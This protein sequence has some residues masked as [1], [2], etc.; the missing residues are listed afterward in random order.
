MKTTILCAGLALA[1]TGG[2][3]QAQDAATSPQ[4]IKAT[5]SNGVLQVI[6][7]P[8]DDR[9]EVM[10]DSAGIR[11][12]GGGVAIAGGVPT[13]SN[14]VLIDIDA[15]AGNDRVSLEGVAMAQIESRVFGHEGNDLL[16][17]GDG[18]DVL[19]GGAGNDVLIGGRGNDVAMGQD[20]SDLLIW[21]DGDGSDFL[22]GG[23]GFDFVQVNGSND[24]DDLD[25][26]AQA[27]GR[28]EVRFQ[29]NNLGLFTLDIGTVEN[30][31]LDG[32]GGNDRLRASGSIP[33]LALTLVGGD[34]DDEVRGGDG[35]DVLRGGAGNDTLIGG[36][37]NDVVLGQDGSDQLVWNDGD[38]SDMLEGGAGFDF[39]QVN[40][41]N[42]AGDDFNIDPDDHQRVRFRRTNLDLFT[43]DIGT[44]ENLDVN[45]QGG[46]DVIIGSTGLVGLISLDLD[47]GEGNDLLIGGGGADRIDGGAG[48]DRCN[49]GG[50][51]DK[52]LDCEIPVR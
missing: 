4:A 8:A 38:G 26:T 45:G 47:G 6:G 37:G 34:G 13:A 9:I 23:E 43:L 20:G 11:V 41:S 25:L 27:N 2:L 22:E 52:L 21:N 7:T 49:G 40:G 30:L 3:A 29:R 32:Q 19:R 14:T 44:V 5:W 35:V 42:T 31:Q 1:L 33:G 16:I 28:S 10:A 12:N 48:Q 17:G 36:R 39:V 51:R 15:G 46:S 50:G 24:A 18:V